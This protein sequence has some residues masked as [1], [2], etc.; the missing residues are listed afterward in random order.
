M[1]GVINIAL[2]E[3]SNEGDT[4]FEKL[5]GHNTHIL[6]AWLNLEKTFRDYG[7]LHNDLKDEVK[8]SL[9]SKIE[10]APQSFPGENYSAFIN[11][12]SSLARAFALLIAE[13]NAEIDGHVIEMM[14][15]YF[16]DE[17]ISE[18]CAYICFVIATQKISS[19]LKL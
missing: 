1:I 10:G 14:K 9:I 11:K 5:L 15:E 6:D 13:D 3:I 8:K 19:A 17:E 7:R 4:P 16:S 2:I 18:L 12:K